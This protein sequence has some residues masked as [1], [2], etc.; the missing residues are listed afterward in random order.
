MFIYLLKMWTRIT[1]VVVAY[2]KLMRAKYKVK[3]LFAKLK[4]QRRS[5]RLSECARA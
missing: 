2:F 4:T 3:S 1:L 5:E